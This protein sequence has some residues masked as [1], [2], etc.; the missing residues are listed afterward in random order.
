MQA[1][2]LRTMINK[3]KEVVDTLI[4]FYMELLLMLEN[5]GKDIDTTEQKFSGQHLESE[6]LG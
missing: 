2:E 4:N 5:A 6:D 3:E 1:T